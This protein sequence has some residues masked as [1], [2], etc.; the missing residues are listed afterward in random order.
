[1]KL[2]KLLNTIEIQSVE[3]SID[4]KCVSVNQQN[5]LETTGLYWL[6]KQFSCQK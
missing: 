2:K 1:M 5:Q 3:I 4:L 6:K